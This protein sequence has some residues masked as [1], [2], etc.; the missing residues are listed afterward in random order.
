MKQKFEKREKDWK[1][2]AI[3]YQVIVDRFAPA[4]DLEKK[5]HLYAPPLRLHEWKK[6]PR[7][8]KY[9][10]KAG[11]WQHEL[12]FWGG[13]LAS[14]SSNLDYIKKFN[15][16]VLYLNPIFKSLTNHKYDTHDYFEVDPAYGNDK[17][18]KDLVKTAHK[19]GLKVVLD[20][21][22]NH[23]GRKSDIFSQALTDQKNPHRE[24]FRFKGNEP[25]CWNNVFNLPEL[26]LHGKAAQN[27]IFAGENSV[28]KYWLKKFDI[29]GWRLDVAY[30]FGKKILSQI[31]AAAKSVKP[32]ATVIGEIW[33]YPEP[34]FPAVDGVINLHARAILLRM[35]SGT[36]EVSE[37][38]QMYRQ[39][40]EDCGIEHMLR[41]WLTLD[42]HDT[43]R[44]ASVLSSGRQQML[45]RALQ[46][47]LPGAV[48]LYY[49]SEF[50]IK[51]ITDPEQRATMP[52][53][54]LQKP[55]AIFRFHEKLAEIR[56]NSR[57][58]RI[59]DFR[60]L[61][62]NSTFAFMRSTDEVGE[63]TIVCANP[64]AEK[65]AAALQIRDG[66]IHDY[67]QF[68]DQLT[69]KVFMAHSGFIDL[70][71]A[72]ESA[73]ILQPLLPDAQKGYSRYKHL[74]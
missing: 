70:E 1:V 20:G 51:G 55:P 44:L 57:A 2:G 56:K 64:A 28:V 9:N 30:E 4:A 24:L 22:F 71:I 63:T 36:I 62:S 21:V 42:N 40:V 53:H 14:L 61:V 33:N 74:E 73:L 38:M 13:D 17:D 69:G 5:K 59:G 41:A 47:T 66:R 12:D 52:W 67:T 16:D 39:M 15:A 32:D 3:V 68:V 65:K 25:V 31:T 43:P 7:S 8:C 10:D 37:A 27:Y 58:L 23:V 50:A 54:K 26:N 19:K 45:A 6:P 72:P 18:F 29:D 46:F 35:L 48:G 60:A 49:G 34:W 11:A